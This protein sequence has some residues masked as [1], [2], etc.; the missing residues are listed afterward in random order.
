MEAAGAEGIGY[1]G[2]AGI[3]PIGLRSFVLQVAP[4]GRSDLL[5]PLVHREAVVEGL[6][7]SHSAGNLR[8]AIPRYQRPDFFEGTI[9]CYRPAQMPLAGF[10]EAV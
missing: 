6:A 5:S 10:L 9:D 3:L 8:C 1:I 4:V 7:L 2:P